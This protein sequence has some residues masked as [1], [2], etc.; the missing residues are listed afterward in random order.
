MIRSTILLI[1]LAAAAAACSSSPTTPATT[2][3]SVAVSSATTS[4]SSFQL[5][6]VA[7]LSDGST[8]DVTSTSTWQSSN[9]QLATVSSAG[10]VTVIA[11]GE[12]DVKA[13]YQNVTGSLHIFVA[14]LPVVNVS[15][16]GVP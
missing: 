3:T 2:I 12:L 16:A 13:T 9:P 7:H 11:T 5:T 8:R 4:G 1:A 15:I 6:A 10:M 14:T